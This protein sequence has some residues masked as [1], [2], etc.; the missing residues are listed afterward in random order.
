MPKF[1]TFVGSLPPCRPTNRDK[2]P[3]K[4]KKDTDLQL[5]F[6][7]FFGTKAEF[8]SGCSDVVGCGQLWKGE[9]EKAI[10]A[11]FHHQ[12]DLYC[13]DLAKN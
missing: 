12:S 10:V 11:S 7:C 1:P 2:M 5:L 13:P 6:F 3:V 8:G 9:R 4:L